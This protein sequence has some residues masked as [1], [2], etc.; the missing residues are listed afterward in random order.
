MTI[1]SFCNVERIT[2]IN[3]SS[4][5]AAEEITTVY[6][7]VVFHNSLE[8]PCQNGESLVEFE[9]GQYI[10]RG[11]YH[12]DQKKDC[13][14]GY[15]LLNGQINGPGKVGAATISWKR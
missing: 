1:L 14:N 3:E 13:N 6:K 2:V 12:Y 9:D 7:S 4:G 11:K 15:W 10:Y 5:N 8:R